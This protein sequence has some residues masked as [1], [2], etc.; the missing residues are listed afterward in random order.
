MGL[1]GIYS[2]PKSGNTWI[3]VII[4]RIM[5]QDFEQVPDLHISPLSNA[6]EFNGLRFFKHHGGRNYKS[7][8]GQ[9]LDTTN[10]IHIR[11]N[12]LDVFVSYLNFLSDNV[13]GKAPIKFSSVDDIRGTDL[14]DLYFSTFITTGHVSAGFADVTGSY[15]QNNTFW[16]NQTEVPA[17]L[18]KYE[19]LV[20]DP[21]ATLEPVKQLLGIDD[22]LIASAVEEAAAVTKPDGKF[23]WKQQEKNYL[24][25]LSQEQIDLFVKYRGAESEAMGYKF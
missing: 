15:F 2:F 24:N 10:V 11:R 12:P 17:I 3:R 6:Q 9:K 18:L 16:M 25:Y 19:D 13:T 23:F 21:I 7:W 8:N 20:S 14:F 4:G 1:V 22:A 5:N